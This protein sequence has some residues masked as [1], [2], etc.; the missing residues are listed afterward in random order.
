MAD[1][2]TPSTNAEQLI[3]EHLD[4]W[5]TAIEQK[6]SSGR[7]SSKK[8]SLHGIKKLRELILELAVRGKLVPQDPNDEPV[9]VLLERIAAEKEQLVKEKKIKKPKVLPEISE[10]EKLFELPESWNWVRLNTVADYNGRPNM[11]PEQI[12]KTTWL[13]DLEDIEKDTSKLIY[14][15]QYSERESK[16][17]KS[18][19]Q[20]GDVLYGKLRPYLNK[21]LIADSDGVCTTEIVAIVPSKAIQAEYL[22]CLLKSPSFISYVSS[23]MYGVKMP[24]LGTQDAICSIH[25]LA[26]INEQK[27]IVA[28]VEELMSLCDALE[29]QT[30]N[31]IAAHQT[32]VEVLLEALLKTPEQ[33]ATAEQAAEQFQQ[34]WQRLSKHFDTLFTTTAS[35]DTLKQ[36]ILQL[37]VMGKLVPQ[38]PNDEPAA[39]LLERIAAEKSQLIKDKK[40]KKQKPLPAITE[41]KKPFE[42]PSGWEWCRLPDLGE[43]ARGKSKHRPRNDPKLYKN[44]TIPLVQTGDVAR[45]VEVIETYTAMYNEVGLAQSQLWPKGTLCITIAANI[46]DTGILGFDACFPD[47]VVGYTCFEP[48]I[49]T[50]YFDYFIRTAKANLEKFAPSTAQKNINLEILSQVLVPCPPLEEFERVVNKVDVLLTLC[51]QLKARLTDEQTTKLHLTDAIVELAL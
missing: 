29:A 32:L 14:R 37:A 42:L 41:E 45:S 1:N 20:K 35:I 3:T 30:E 2:K 25:P 31:S 43:L 17:N 16:S 26:P 13:L 6:S 5:T 12:N 28:K 8:F 10:D 15:A 27:R 7:G 21:V 36:T 50:K 22:R 24:R 34:N 19:F 48:Q 49:P 23:L 9:S 4:I 47:S 51:D 46:A 38:N 44:G 18:T 33:G 39:K 11:A 40:I